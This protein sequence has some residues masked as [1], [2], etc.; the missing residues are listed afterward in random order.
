MCAG[1]FCPWRRLL[2]AFKKM[3]KGSV[4]FYRGERV[5][6]ELGAFVVCRD[7]WGLSP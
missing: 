4:L 5:H 1:V 2:R 6:L 7:P 3:R